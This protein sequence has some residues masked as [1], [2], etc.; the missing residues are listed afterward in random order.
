MRWNFL[1]SF[2]TNFHVK[3]WVIVWIKFL[4]LNLFVEFFVE[5]LSSS[6]IFEVADYWCSYFLKWFDVTDSALCLYRP[7][8]LMAVTF[9]KRINHW[10]DSQTPI[11]GLKDL[12]AI[13]YY[14]DQEHKRNYQNWLRYKCL[15]HDSVYQ[16][17]EFIC[18]CRIMDHFPLV[19][20]RTALNLILLLT[21]KNKIQIKLLSDMFCL[22]D[23]VEL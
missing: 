19:W 20:I 3:A 21:K 1:F 13:S 4:L 12:T 6:K 23:K 16:P 18:D 14:T 5:F 7:A 2:K 11:N 10:L 15:S 17:K 8:I 9:F 22:N